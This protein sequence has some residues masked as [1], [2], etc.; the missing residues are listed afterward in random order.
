MEI[1]NAGLVFRPTLLDRKITNYIVLHHAA[2]YGDVTA[3]HNYHQNEH[4]W[5]GIGYHFYVR[6][7]GTI[8]EGRPL[9]KVGGHTAKFNHESIGI[10]FEG[11]FSK[12]I[13]CDEQIKA[14]NWLVNY[15]KT[16]FPEAKI[17]RHKELNNTECPGENFPFEEITKTNLNTYPVWAKIE[18][19][20][21]ISRGIIKGDDNGMRWNDPVT[22]AE[23]A[24]IL[25][26]LF[27][28]KC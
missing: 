7:D 21:A 2:G 6:T 23:I 16:L 8:F 25:Y 26:R 19:E 1:K 14:G 10:C 9:M 11:D 12:D 4:G 3:I 17:V 22:R 13:M 24:V 28:E 27:N 15:C 5:L 18:C 20:W